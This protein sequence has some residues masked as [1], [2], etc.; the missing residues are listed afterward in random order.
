MVRGGTREVPIGFAAE[1]GLP[2]RSRPRNGRDRP[3]R[4]SRRGTAADVEGLVT[5]RSRVT[6]SSL[7]RAASEERAGC[8]GQCAWRI[9]SSRSL[10]SRSLAHACSSRHSIVSSSSS[11][12]EEK[13]CHARA[14]GL[15]E[16]ASLAVAARAASAMASPTSF[17]PE[18]YAASHSKR[19]ATLVSAAAASDRDRCGRSCG[20]PASGSTG[21]HADAEVSSGHRASSHSSI[22][23][24]M[25]SASVLRPQPGHALISSA[26]RCAR[27]AHVSAVWHRRMR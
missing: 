22:A 15:S 27:S 2:A 26:E 16:D 6:P 20:D 19:R 11:R 14:T 8:V 5:T 25:I 4:A 13:R 12:T 21:R 10:K 24:R 17:A 7:P 3:A 9:R 1:A 23:V 18:R